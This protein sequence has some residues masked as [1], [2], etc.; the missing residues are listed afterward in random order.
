MCSRDVALIFASSMA[1]AAIVTSRAAPT[2]GTDNNASLGI[3]ND[4]NR[5]RDPRD[6]VLV[7]RRGGR[8]II[9]IIIIIIVR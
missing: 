8:S 7:L 6:T 3:H 1:T 9:I 4:K 5:R 2:T